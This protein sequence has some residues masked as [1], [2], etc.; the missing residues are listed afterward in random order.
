MSRYNM[1]KEKINYIENLINKLRNEKMDNTMIENYFWDNEKEIMAAYPFL[2]T[3]II[4][5]NDRKM[6]DYMLENLRMV[7]LGAK[8][9]ETAN[10]D[11]GD[12]I[13]NDYINP[14]FKK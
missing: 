12:K 8:T 5:T 14:Q 6:L 7:E 9:K 2:V 4:E 3:S 13:M 11:V 10:K 1:I